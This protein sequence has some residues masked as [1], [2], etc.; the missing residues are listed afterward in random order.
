MIKK[1][2]QYFLNII[3]LILVTVVVGYLGYSVAPMIPKLSNQKSKLY[4]SYHELPNSLKWTIYEFELTAHKHKVD[5]SK[6]RKIRYGLIRNPNW[7]L[8]GYYDHITNTV[9]INYSKPQNHLH[10]R[11]ILWHEFGHGILYYSHDPKEETTHIMNSGYSKYLAMNWEQRKDQF[12]TEPIKWRFDFKVYRGPMM[13][14]TQ[15]YQQ[16]L[17][18]L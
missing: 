17:K 5:V 6:V 10:I 11:E 13:L 15:K 8:G 4:Y 3:G 16:Y 18:K 7:N 14:L 1:I 9:F 2:A 12:F